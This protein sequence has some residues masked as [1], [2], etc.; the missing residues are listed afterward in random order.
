MFGTLKNA[1]SRGFGFISTKAGIDFFFHHS[2]YTGDWKDLL[3][4]HV[5]EETIELEFENDP[6][7]SDGPRAI[8]VRPKVVVVESFKVSGG[9]A[10]ES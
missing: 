8:K 2:A 3:R 4:R 5:S 1:N 9:E 7:G 6:T 10:C